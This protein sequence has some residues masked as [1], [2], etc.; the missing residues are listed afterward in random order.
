MAWRE[1]EPKQGTGSGF[2]QVEDA[3]AP[4]PVASPLPVGEWFAPNT[5]GHKIPS[6]GTD[7]LGQRYAFHA[8]D[9]ES[10]TDIPGSMR[11]WLGGGLNL[12]RSL[13]LG[14]PIL[15][16]ISGTVIFAKD[17]R[18]ERMRAT[19]LDII[20]ALTAGGRFGESAL[21]AYFR[22]LTGNYVI[23]QGEQGYA[24]LAHATTG[25]VCVVEGEQVKAGQPVARVGGHRQFDVAT[26]PDLRTA[27]GLPS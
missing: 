15:S 18:P 19:P 1:R 3:R 2:I 5:P 7:Q 6:H 14:A 12:R 24:F 20:R 4:I 11:Y 27:N 10:I 23:I 17:G 8:S 22:A 16:P 25:S 13:G 9:I 26:P 21:R